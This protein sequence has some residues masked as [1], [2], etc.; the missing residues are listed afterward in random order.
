MTNISNK[1]TGQLS[2]ITFGLSVLGIL[3]RLLT[4]LKESDDMLLIGLYAISFFLNT[5]I[6]VQIFVYGSGEP[7]K[8]GTSDKGPPLERKPSSSGKRKKLD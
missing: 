7:A 4:I 8:T 1:S 3:G 5:T 2:A 6:L